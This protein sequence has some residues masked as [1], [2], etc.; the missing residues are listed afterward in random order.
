MTTALFWLALTTLLIYLIVAVDL[1]RGNRSVRFLSDISNDLPSPAPKVSVIVA[2]R[3]EARNIREALSSLLQLDYPDYELIVVDDRSEDAT[4]AIVDELASDDPRLQAVHVAELPP[5]WLGKNHA[6]W[7]GSRIAT[8]ELLLFTDADIIMEPTILSRSV[9]FL[10]EQRIDHLAMTPVMRMPSLF[11]AMFGASFIIFF[12]LFARPWKARDPKSP[13]HI[14]IGA[15]NLITADAYRTIGGH[16]TIR[17]RPDDDMKLGKIVKKGGFKQDIIYGRGF[18]EVEWYASVR[19]VINGLEKN[20]FSGTDYRV[21]YALCGVLFYLLCGVWPWLALVM[22]TGATQILN[23][24]VVL[25]II[26]IFADTARFHDA[27]SWHAVGFPLCAGFFSWIIVR[28]LVLNL[29][30]GGITWRGTFYRLSELKKN[31]M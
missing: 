30:Q 23:G 10:R 1:L 18:L 16:E 4:G 19:E 9:T 27:R 20:A 25:I 11:L 22:T 8:G 15:F 7:M 2:A 5:D 17:L 24:A 26:L 29:V 21:G 13:C 6:L 12:S 28:T 31:R 14:G 3:N